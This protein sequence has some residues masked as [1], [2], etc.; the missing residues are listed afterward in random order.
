MQDISNE[1]SQKQQQARDEAIAADRQGN[2]KKSGRDLVPR[3]R[4]MEM[5]VPASATVVLLSGT[6]IVPNFFIAS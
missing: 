3:R 6:S 4:F 5:V 2:M 1:S